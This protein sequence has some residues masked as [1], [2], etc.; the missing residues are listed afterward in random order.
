MPRAA[1]RSSCSTS[2]TRRCRRSAR[3]PGTRATWPSSGRDVVSVPC[4]L[5]S[6]CPTV[7]AL[8]WSGRSWLH[9]TVRRRARRLADRRHRRP[10]P[11]RSRGKRSL[12][13]SALIAHLRDPDRR[14]VCVHNTPGRGRL[15]AC[16][17][18]PVDAAVRALRGRGRTGR[19]R[20]R[21]GAGAA[22]PSDRRCASTAAR[23][24]WPTSGPASAGCARSSKPPPNRPV[25]AVTGATREAARTAD[26][27]V[28]TEAV[29]HRVRPT[30]TSSPSSTSTPSCSRRGTAPP[31]RRWPCW[32][33]RR[34]LVGPRHD[35]GAIAGADVPAAA[36]E[37]AAGRVARRPR[38]AGQG[39]GGAAA[40]TGPAA[41]RALARV[42]GAGA[43]EFVAATGLD[44]CPRRR[45]SAAFAP[46][47]WDQLGAALAAHPRPKGSRLRIEVDP[48]RR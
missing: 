15:L 47:T 16:R 5:V 32:S 38:P 6:P 11:T 19:R 37:V 20:R 17:Y 41:V 4:V 26:V 24:R 8:H 36:P 30:P 3:R 43:D 25:V 29:L 42:S 33:A 22:G 23:G 46:P 14:V 18:V 39:R 13:T 1:L 7:T 10:Q 45:R 2:T 28:G 9:P 35:G 40:L 34:G 21:C 48:P 31:N 44:V 27:F 12:L